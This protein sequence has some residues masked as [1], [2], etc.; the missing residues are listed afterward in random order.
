MKKITRTVTTSIIKA[1]EVS[2]KDGKVMSIPLKEVVCDNEIITDGAK[3]LKKVQKAYG[4]EKQ[5]VITGI[6]KK[7][8]LYGLDYDTF[9]KYAKVITK[10]E[11]EADAKEETEKTS[12]EK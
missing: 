7:E 9:M 6:E 10:E 3:A 8:V 4:K 2:F 12:I 1:S 11:A 5:Y